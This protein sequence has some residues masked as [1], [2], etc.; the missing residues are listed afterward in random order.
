[1]EVAHQSATPLVVN[2]RSTEMV[3]VT[4][5]SG[6]GKS[7]VLRSLEDIGYFCVDNLP[8]DLLPHFFQLLDRF[9]VNGQRVALGVDV[10]SG[11]NIELLVDNLLQAK[12]NGLPLTVFF[13]STSSSILLKRYQTTR[14]KHPLGANAPMSDLIDQ[15]KKLLKPLNAIADVVVETD[16]CTPHQ[17]RSIVRSYFV[18]AD[19]PVLVVHAI[20][21]GFKYGVPAQCNFVYDVRSLPNPYFIDQLRPLDG[22]S[23][24]LRAY[25]FEQPEVK[26]YWHRMIDFIDYS[27]ARAYKEGRFFITVAIGCTGGRHRSVAF[28]H[29]LSQ[30][31][32]ENVMFVVKH[33]DIN[34]EPM[35]QEKG[36]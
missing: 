20:S 16:Q 26:E 9:Q 15:E 31:T 34:R 3:I 32:L 8:I 6:A 4:G 17:L 1:M 36:E 30:R 19:A 29:E 2:Q 13:L 25:F 33:R 22:T 14:R 35:I 23:A 11:T 10:R 12:Q 28:I 7:T 18:R 27:I 21:F 5:Y 24:E